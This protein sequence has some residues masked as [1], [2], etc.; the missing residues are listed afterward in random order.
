MAMIQRSDSQNN[1]VPLNYQ[2]I[3][4]P[5]L[6]LLKGEEDAI[7]KASKE[8]VLKMKV[9][10]AIINESNTILSKTPIERKLE[11]KRLLKQSRE[12]LKRIF[13]LSFAYRVTLD[14]RYAE[15]AEKEML[16]VAAFSDWGPSHYLDVAEMTTGMAIGYDWLY[17]NLS[18]NSRNT[19]AAS[20]ITLGL[21]P[22][23][24]MAKSKSWL[25]GTYNWNQVCNTGMTLGALAIYE[26]NPEMA[27]HII[28]RSIT[29]IKFPMS[30]YAPDGA[31]PEGYNYW[32]FGTTYNTLF[33]TTIEKAF[34]QDFGLSE[35]KGFLK[36]SQYMLNMLGT[37]GESFNYSDAGAI[38]RVV[39]PAMFWFQNKTQD[40]SI[41]YGQQK[42]LKNCKTSDLAKDR[43]LPALLIW[44]KDLKFSQITKPKSLI[45]V[46]QGQTPVAL[47]RT[48]WDDPNAL[49][50]GF[51][52]G[53]PISS[54]SHMDIG[55][56]IFDY[57]G[58]RW[59]MDLGNENYGAIE[60][61]GIDLFNN[62]QNSQRWQIFRHNNYHHNTLTVDSAFQNVN[63]YA[64]IISYNDAPDSLSASTDITSLYS[65]ALDSAIRTI[66][67]IDKEKVVVWD[68][69]K[70]SNK[71]VQ[72]K[73][74]LVTP[75]TVTIMDDHTIELSLHNKT[76]W[77]KL[78]YKG[79]A[80]P[81]TTPATPFTS[82]EQKNKGVQL[83]GFDFELTPNELAEWQITFSA[84]EK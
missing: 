48:S 66:A 3:P 19:I 77:M 38:E 68:K 45:W 40:N 44:A 46:G 37:K 28:N 41:L 14:N 54:H 58:E 35:A 64:S 84:K 29:A 17:Q 18:L 25:T 63:G 36:S 10:E 61:Q 74:T 75:A 30:V 49:F 2:P 70:N 6:L 13:F 9:N 31:Y 76:L 60:A 7:I 34:G 21:T 1:F 73:W 8:E 33:L 50:V 23:L 62:K 52:G 4:H 27:N 11:G 12:F 55:S 78:N 43:F 59:A 72:L 24:D 67:I 79:K 15:R 42:F 57:L 82:Y 26:S 71:L 51:K 65:P 32:G 22:S 83:T 56:F 39:E 81:F 20:I 16:A 80:I 47:M 69:I 53:S 5:R